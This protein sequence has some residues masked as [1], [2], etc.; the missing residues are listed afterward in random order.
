MCNIFKF[1][2][3][4]PWNDEKRFDQIIHKE[5]TRIRNKY[6]EKCLAKLIVKKCKFKCPQDAIS[7][8]KLKL[9]FKMLL[10]VTSV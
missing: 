2:T 3:K 6:M 9:F 5:E 10:M 8:I 1:H 4:I 7:P